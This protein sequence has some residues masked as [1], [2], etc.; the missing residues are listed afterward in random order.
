MDVMDIIGPK[1]GELLDAVLADLNAGTL[2]EHGLR[3]DDVTFVSDLRLDTSVTAAINAVIQAQQEANQAEQRVRQ[4]EALAR[5][6]AA[7]AQ[8]A[9]DSIL[10]I[11]QAQAAAN[12]IL[13]RSLTDRVVEYQTIQKW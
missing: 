6:R 12:E 10:V 3:F 4:N 7:L 5:S 9:A 2:A 11:A 8:G 1:K 13:A